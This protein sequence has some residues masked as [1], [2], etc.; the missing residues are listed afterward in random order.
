MSDHCD[1]SYLQ[2]QIEEADKQLS[3]LRSS[4][5]QLLDEE[6]LVEE[7]L[8]SERKKEDELLSSLDTLD[9]TIDKSRGEC[10][11]SA[12]RAEGLRKRFEEESTALNDNVLALKQSRERLLE[13]MRRLGP[14]LSRALNDKFADQVANCFP[15]TVISG[16]VK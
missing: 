5:A 9:R 2:K 12:Q 7:A 16:K 10:K 15:H 8:A 14:S 1:D 13:S 4:V 11:I 6:L 3:G